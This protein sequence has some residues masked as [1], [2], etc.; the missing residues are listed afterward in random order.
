[1]IIIYTVFCI[2]VL[3][4]QYMPEEAPTPSDFSVLSS[5][6]PPTSEIVYCQNTTHTGKVSIETHHPE[7]DPIVVHGGSPDFCWNIPN[8]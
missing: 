3:S 7:K 6:T 5:L 8:C 1:M 4:L 2:Y